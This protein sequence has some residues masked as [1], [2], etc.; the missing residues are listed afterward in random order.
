MEIR[1]EMEFVHE[2]IKDEIRK[3]INSIYEHI[4]IIIIMIFNIIIMLEI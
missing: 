4:I 2:H 3:E 1:K